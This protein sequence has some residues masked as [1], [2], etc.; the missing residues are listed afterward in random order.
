MLYR[1]VLHPKI[2]KDFKQLSASQT[3]LVFKQFKKMEVSPELGVL[4]GNKSN[5]KLEGCRKLYVDKKKIRIVYRIVDEEI[6]VEVIVIGKRD[7]MA[8]YKE[9][10]ERIEG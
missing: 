2:T 8:V 6:L 5:Y 1:L 7:D 4:L 9:A 3:Q 10:N